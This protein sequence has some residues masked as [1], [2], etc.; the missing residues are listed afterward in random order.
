MDE[1]RMHEGWIA[2]VWLRRRWD[3]DDIPVQQQVVIYKIQTMAKSNNPLLVQCR[4]KIGDSIVIKQYGDKTVLSKYPDMSCVKRTKLQKANNNL[5]AKAVSYAKNICDD[6]RL[7]KKYMTKI[8]KGQS[9]YHFAIKEFYLLYA[10]VK[11][12]T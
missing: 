11:S 6:P 12:K 1:R 10:T 8:K 7:R 4:G 5:F 2:L 3:I 9:I